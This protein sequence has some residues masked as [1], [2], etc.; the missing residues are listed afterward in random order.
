[1]HISG[2]QWRLLT[3]DDVKTTE[4]KNKGI[5]DELVV[6]DWL[7]IEQMDD[8]IWWLRVGDVRIVA[9]VSSQGQVTVDVERGAYSNIDGKTSFDSTT[10]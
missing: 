6:D 8:N 10:D 4:I 2:T 1:M 7:H 5:F 3:H 9:T